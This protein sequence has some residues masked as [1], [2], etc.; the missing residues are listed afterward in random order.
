M[1][2]NLASSAENQSETFGEII[3]DIGSTNP[4]TIGFGS[5]C[6]SSCSCAAVF[7]E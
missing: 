2:S 1:N 4:L 3:H 7:V 5:C 6:C